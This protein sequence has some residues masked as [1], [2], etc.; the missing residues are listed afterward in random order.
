MCGSCEKTHGGVKIGGGGQKWVASCENMGSGC[1]KFC[2]FT[3]EYTTY[4]YY[5]LRKGR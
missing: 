1:V 5:G 4:I 3:R 2:K